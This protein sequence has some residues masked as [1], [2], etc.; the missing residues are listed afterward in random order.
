MG[1]IAFEWLYDSDVLFD[2]VLLL[3]KIAYENHFSNQFKFK[4]CAK[5][6]CPTANIKKYSILS[7][8]DIIQHAHLIFTIGNEKN[9][10]CQGNKVTQFT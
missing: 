7:R 10:N 8:F 1:L 9:P 5:K 2:S 4:N 3:N 6:T